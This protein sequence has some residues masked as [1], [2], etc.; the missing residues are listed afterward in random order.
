MCMFIICSSVPQ[1][2]EVVYVSLKETK[3]NHDS[4][5]SHEQLCLL[6]FIMVPA[7]KNSS[8]RGSKLGQ[9]L[10]IYCCLQGLL[11]LLE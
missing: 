10:A 9:F 3:I 6:A 2:L 8:S 7:M 1:V 11:L 5:N 4:S